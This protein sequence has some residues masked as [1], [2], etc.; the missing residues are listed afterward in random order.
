M[1]RIAQ[2][3]TSQFILRRQGNMI[4][5][6][7]RVSAIQE[8]P[9]YVPGFVAFTLCLLMCLGWASLPAAAQTA[10]EGT[11]QGTV[12]DSTGAVIPGATVTAINTATNRT[13]VRTT[14]SA[15][16]FNIAPLLPGTYRIQV[17]AKGF[18]TLIQENVVV[19]ALQTRTIDP[20]LTVGAQSQQITVTAAPPVLNTADA[21]L[22][23]TIENST[24][25]NL[26][27]QMTGSTKRDPTA[28]GTL[29]PGAQSGTR[30]PV[31][32]GT[33][34]YLGQLY[35]DG[36]PA[37]T[38]NQ[39]GDNRVVSLAMSVEAVD[40]F[41]V[42]TSTPPAEYMGA[43]AMNF[44]MKSGGVKYHGQVSDFIRN[45]VF[46]TWGFTSKAAT[47]VTATGTKI[48]APKPIEHQNEL[49]ASFGGKVP[50]TGNKL[51]FF[52]AY[53]KYHV[54]TGANPALYSIP[55]KAMLSGDFTELNGNV[56]SGG[57]SGEGS[58]NPPILFDPNSN[59]CSG[60]T[61]TRLPFVGVKNGVATYNV[62]PS[63]MLSPI[64]KAMAAFMPDPT[65]PSTLYNNYLGG[66]PKGWDA[67]T[68]D[69]RVDYDLNA[70]QR[71]SASRA[72]TFT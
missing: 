47:M 71:I 26:P 59:S 57:R 70:K 36:M 72:T 56:G 22:G 38:V 5:R 1:W 2:V 15:G 28:F 40:Q 31:I 63:A 25:S 55:S 9:G 41:Q 18:Q 11:L 37:T 66:W 7:V 65:N 69:W 13:T 12:S 33:G 48:Q 45:T 64:A 14:T 21:T 19:N 54:R 51:F 61:C 20:V 32:G 46:D 68:Y 49:S 43:G 34:N 62:I 3:D 29:T 50:K 24:Y 44:T 58:D 23:L 16:F 6:G 17:E 4:T 35:L 60:T 67:H 30:L 52:F 27:I 53:D 10:G 39:Q 8:K 42:L